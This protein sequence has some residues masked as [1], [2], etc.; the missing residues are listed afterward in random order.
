MRQR[1]ADLHAAVLEG[2]DVLDLGAG[3]ELPG[4]VAPDGEEEL[5]QVDVVLE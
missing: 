5:Q 2:E 4:A 3:A 1:D